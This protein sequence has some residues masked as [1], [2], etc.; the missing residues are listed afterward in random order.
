[1]NILITGG[2][3]FI[4]SH[5]ADNLLAEGHTVVS[6][7]NLLRGRLSNMEEA[8]KNPEFTFIR[9]DILDKEEFF[10]VFKKYS[11]DVIFHMAA[12]SDIASSHD[13]PNVDFDNTLT[14]TYN[15]LL[16]MKEFGVKNLVFAST[17]AIYGDTGVSVDEDFGP[18][19]PI[20]HYG[21]SKLASEAYISSFCENYG[22]KAWITRFPNV[23]G[24]R[25]THGAIYDFINK[26]RKNPAELEVLGDGTQIKPYLYVKDLVE[27]I[28]MV[29]KN[30]NEQ[31]NYF[32]IGVESRTTVKEMAEMVIEEMNLNASI[33]YTGGDRGWV[34]DVPQFSY[35]LDKIHNLGW[36]AKVS[37]N[38]AV[39]KSIQYI[40]EQDLCKL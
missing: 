20:S 2:A 9:G 16:A 8:M 6:F 12:N 25:A 1:M 26:L 27:A 11:F 21:A 40:L 36:S 39:R 13:N 17:S 15:V 33:R 37:S 4:G 38:E 3:G 19:F 28:I 30:T 23:V 10:N 34:G 24:E 29:W 32:N 14:T 35:S 18:L 7:D 5:L 31:V 22:L